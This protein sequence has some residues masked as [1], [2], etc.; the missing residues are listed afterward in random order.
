MALNLKPDNPNTPRP[1]P[2]RGTGPGPLTAKTKIIFAGTV[3]GVVAGAS[4]IYYTLYKVIPWDGV[5]VSALASIGLV[6]VLIASR[7]ADPMQEQQ[8]AY[9]AR[10]SEILA[11]VRDLKAEGKSPIRYLESQGF[12]IYEI[13]QQILKDAEQAHV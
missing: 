8:D 3:F 9:E 13:R 1:I 12:T 6:W 7:Q 2:R 5:V 11:R 4:A 10:R